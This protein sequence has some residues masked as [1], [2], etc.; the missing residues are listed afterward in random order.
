MNLHSRVTLRFPVRVVSGCGGCWVEARP[1]SE[2]THALTLHHLVSPDQSPALAVQGSD[3]PEQGAY[4]QG[5]TVAGRPFSAHHAVTQLPVTAPGDSRTHR[6]CGQHCIPLEQFVLEESAWPRTVS[7]FRT[8]VFVFPGLSYA[9]YSVLVRSVLRCRLGGRVVR[10]CLR[11][12]ARFTAT[13]QPFS[14]PAHR[15]CDA[16]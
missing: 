12:R 4:F 6:G 8:R 3:L 11:S 9:S 15:V 13:R 5:G 7:L 2:L 10:Q 14:S 16:H 1:A